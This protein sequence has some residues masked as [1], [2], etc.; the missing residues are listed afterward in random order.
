MVH[1]MTAYMIEKRWFIHNQKPLTILSSV[2][3]CN[4]LFEL[5]GITLSSTTTCN[6]KRERVCVCGGHDEWRCDVTEP[7][8][9][10]V[11]AA[12]ATSSSN[13]RKAAAVA[14][15]QTSTGKKSKL[16]GCVYS[17]S[18]PSLIYIFF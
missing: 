9:V 13:S 6:C 10:T 2:D 11:A 12:A 16:L 15:A 7:R 3:Y 8:M 17:P 1:V 14:I 4:P 18:S 5:V